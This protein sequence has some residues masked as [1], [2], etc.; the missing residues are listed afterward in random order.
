M[1]YP[2]LRGRQFEL[3]A[4]RDFAESL[5]GKT[6]V[7]FP[8]IE[9]VR[10]NKNAL[11][12]AAITMSNIGMRYGIILN[13]EYGECANK[14]IDFNSENDFPSHEMWS[15]TFIVNNNNIN[16]ISQIVDT[17]NYND[18]IIIL[19][20][21][22]SVSEEE[23]ISLIGNP[24]ISKIITDS[25][26]RRIKSASLSMGKE[27]ITL[28]DNFEAKVKNAIYLNIDEELFSEEFA[29]YSEENYSGFS[30]YTVI[31]NEFREGGV[32]PNVVAIHLTYQ[33]QEDQIFVK[34]FCS[35][36]NIDDNSNI[37]GKFGEAAQYA[38]SFFDMHPSEDSVAINILR[39]Y[40]LNGSF[41]GLGM[42]KKISILHHLLLIQRISK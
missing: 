11:K 41:P 21:T 15:P 7:V 10:K 28:T 38:V 8:I 27:I 36:R 26:R 31:P 4:L 6:S 2:Y 18:V 34:H 39:N 29:Y 32:L 13:P 19:L 22:S 20:K 24:H 9:P 42:L 1:Y 16:Q 33:K 14:Y 37:Q 5:Q 17:N 25:P 35:T 23:V 3:L 40:L 30:D 12:R